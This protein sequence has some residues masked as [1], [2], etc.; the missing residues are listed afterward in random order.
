MGTMSGDAST[1]AAMA[2]ERAPIVPRWEWRIFGPDLGE[3]GRV[4]GAMTPE[5]LEESAETYVLGLA[6][7][8]SVKIRDGRMDVK[9]LERVDG[10]G[11]ELWRPIL[12]AAFPLAAADVATTLAA[13]GAPALSLAR[14]AYTLDQLLGEVIDPNPGLLAVAVRKHRA[15]HTLGGCRAELTELRAGAG[16]TRTVAIE[17]EDPARVT[18]TVR[19]LGLGER[20]VVCVARGLKAL[21][22]FGAGRGAV[23][24]VGTNSVKFHVGERRAG[25][26]LRTIA[27]RAEVT[28]LGEGVDE[29]GRLGAAPIARTVEAIALMVDEAR[30]VGAGTITAVGTAA[31]RIAPNAAEL[32]DAVEARTG[33]RV[34]VISGEEEARLAYLATVAGLG[35]RVGQ[36]SIVVFD[37]GGGSSQFTFGHGTNAD[38]R[39]S[40]NVGAVRLTERFGLDKP[41]SETALDAALDGIAAELVALR[42]RPR[43]DAVVGMGGA[44][45]N[46]AAVR[47]GL[48]TYDPDVVQGTVLDRS[49]IDR[50]IDVYRART[51]EQRRAIVGLQPNRAEVI[52]AGACVV[53]TVLAL[54]GRDEL[55]VSDRGLRHGVI[56]ERLAVE[57]AA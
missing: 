30:R 35:P 13:L 46:L 49:E 32:V 55:T 28:R 25:G 19:E 31:L 18:A 39:F 47:H 53:R 26:A 2:P 45:T 12:K 40:V 24:D 44:V 21:V 48:A 27:D 51:A 10:D 38:E 56:A 9:R 50:Q 42:G 43:P 7:D 33:V 23:I 37:S 16:G 6:S 8:A 22:G 36:G 11:L 1:V 52:L 5:R 20:R 54:L 41:V 17:S 3:A 34:E 14:S 15:H 57:A 29:T 4:L